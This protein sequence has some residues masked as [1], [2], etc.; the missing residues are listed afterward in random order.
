MSSSRVIAVDWSGRRQ[1][2]RRAIW[3]AEAV[4]GV[5][6]RLED[7]RTR[8]ELTTHLLETA[9]DDP[10]LLVGL[11]FSFSLPAWFLAERGLAAGPA[12]WEVSEETIEAWLSCTA[13]PFWGL[14]GRRRP[15]LPAHLRITEERL[16]TIGGVRPKSTFQVSGAG[17]V[18]AGSLRGF[19]V[20][21]TLRSH[22]FAIWPFDDASPPAAFEVWP[23]AFSAGVVKSDRS[24]R[25]A[26][27]AGLVADAHELDPVIP[28][29]VRDRATESEDAFDALVS[30]LGMA[31][32]T[33][34]L[35]SRSRTSDPVE[36]LEGAVWVPP[37]TRTHPSPGT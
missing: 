15:E 28:G 7:G 21:R 4:G 13:P 29:W 30:V 18:G 14:P 27:V 35:R 3:L 16:G 34:D 6:T 26:H 22:G 17:S 37:A 20:L 12:L 24:A 33:D 19:A 23:R 32:Q 36:R 31:R 8:H 2:E 25:R 5:V 9:A 10:D 1:G 11:D